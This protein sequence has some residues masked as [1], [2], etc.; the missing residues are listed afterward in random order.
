[1]P[2]LAQLYCYYEARLMRFQSRY[3]LLSK[4]QSR[5]R[6]CRYVC[7]LCHIN[8]VGRIMWTNTRMLKVKFWAVK[9]DL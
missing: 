4:V 8:C 2:V 1:M 6:V 7:Y 3:T 9:T 5:F